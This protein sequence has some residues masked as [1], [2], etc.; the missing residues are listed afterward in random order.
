[1][2]VANVPA[3]KW[4]VLMTIGSLLGLA[5]TYSSIVSVA[6]EKSLRKFN[7]DLN[8]RVELRFRNRA[9]SEMEALAQALLR[10][11]CT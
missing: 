1:M 3:I 6:E 2:S 5:I 7:E 10:W 8:S 11:G 9:K 4:S